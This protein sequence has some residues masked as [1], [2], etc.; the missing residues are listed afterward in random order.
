MAKQFTAA[1]VMLL[2]KDGKISLDDKLIRFVP[3]A[4]D[5]WKNITVRHLLTHTSGFGDFPSEID[6]RKDYTEVHRFLLGVAHDSVNNDLVTT[7]VASMLTPDRL[8]EL[9]AL[10]NSLTLPVAI[11]HS[12]ELIGRR[13]ENGMRVYRYVFNDIGKTLSLTLKLTID[14]KIAEFDLREIT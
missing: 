6:L 1:A 9:A 10:L 2:A 4:P 14:D 11:I 12:E 3:D 5:A 13:D 7:T 8:S